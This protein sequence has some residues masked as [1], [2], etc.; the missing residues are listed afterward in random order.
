MPERSGGCRT[1]GFRSWCSKRATCTVVPQPTPRKP[2]TPSLTPFNLGDVHPNAVSKKWP[3]PQ[4][5]WV[6]VGLSSCSRVVSCGYRGLPPTWAG[7]SRLG[8]GGDSW[9]SRAQLRTGCTS[10]GD[11][12][13]GRF[14]WCS[15]RTGRPRCVWMRC[16]GPTVGRA[17]R[18]A[19]S[20][21]VLRPA[22]EASVPVRGGA[23]VADVLDLRDAAG[24][25]PALRAA[26]GVPAQEDSQQF[27]DC[28]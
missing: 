27:W 19:A 26:A 24:G 9:C 15:A 20:R 28:R 21:P 10:C 6:R 16:R 18:A 22:R 4:N 8:D 23:G 17:A 11:S 14:S 1:R 3:S 25:L 7:S 5:Q 2:A 12:C 13:T